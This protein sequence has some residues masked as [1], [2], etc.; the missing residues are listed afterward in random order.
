MK[1]R[2]GMEFRH[3]LWLEKMA[4]DPRGAA[5]TGTAEMIANRLECGVSAK[6]VFEELLRKN[7]RLSLAERTKVALAV[8]VLAEYG[9][10]LR[11][12]WNSYYN[13]IEWA[14]AMELLAEKKIFNPCR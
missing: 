11:V 9:D 1:I 4:K 10:P 5:I 8:S 3:C 7:K 13:S 6:E 14:F 2:K 12:V